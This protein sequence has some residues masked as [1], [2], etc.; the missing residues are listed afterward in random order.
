[1]NPPRVNND[2]LGEMAAC[3][4]PKMAEHID[5]ILRANSKLQIWIMPVVLSKQAFDVLHDYAHP[6]FEIRTLGQSRRWM[7]S[8]VLHR[9]SNK[10]GKFAMVRT[11]KQNACLVV[12][13]GPSDFVAST[14]RPLTN[15]LYPHVSTI[16]L[17][18]TEI[19]DTLSELERSVDSKVIVRKI[20]TKTPASVK[21]NKPSGRSDLTHTRVPYGE[22][23]DEVAN[24]GRQVA[25]VSFYLNEPDN[26]SVLLHR[27]G[28][29]KFKHAL[30]PFSNNVLPNMVSRLEKMSGMYTGRSR[31]DNDG[32]IAPLVI[33]LEGSPFKDKEQNRL[34][35]K[36]MESMKNAGISVYHANPYMHMSL[37]D[38]LDGSSFN[39]WV[40]SDG[41]ITIVPQIRA[42]RT[43][44]ARLTDHILERFREGHVKEHE[45]FHKG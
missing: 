28:L 44:I 12:T 3:G 18:T 43:A 26:M 33:E 29:L 14:L 42:T 40:L 39:I 38:Y 11:G 17:T 13:D 23:F 27:N 36:T 2:W 24:N 32:K 5:G 34:L 20:S 31:S 15:M 1:M 9:S 7:C 35:I 22:A 21:D 16:S 45:K 41:A 37:V 8:E 10:K 6:R 19:R 4:W 30:L 25:N